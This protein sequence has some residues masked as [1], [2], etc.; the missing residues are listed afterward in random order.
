MELEGGR[1]FAI[2]RY[3]HEVRGALPALDLSAVATVAV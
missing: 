1:M 3:L 2:D